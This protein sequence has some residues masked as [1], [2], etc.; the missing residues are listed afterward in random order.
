VAVDAGSL[1][2]YRTP[3]EQAR[4]KH[5]FLTHTHVDHLASLPVFLDTVYTGDGNCVTIYGNEAV[6]ECL[7]CDLFNDRLWPDFIRISTERPPYLRL[8]EVRAGETL[9]VD[10]LQVI[11]IPVNH[12]VPTFGY[13]IADREAAVAIVSDTG[14]TEEIWHRA[15][16]YVNLKAVFLEATMPNAL[17]WLADVAKH[18]T[19]REFARETQKL[20]RPVRWIAVHIQP[21]HRE[22][23][24]RELEALGIPGLEIGRFGVPYLF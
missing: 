18:L 14:P 16:E 21:R 1:G 9:T 13:L 11:P 3:A 8:Q 23:T 17:T 6:L 2:L 19:P 7:R 5:L 20:Q 4:I 12:T 24:M 10:G 22:Q 15:N